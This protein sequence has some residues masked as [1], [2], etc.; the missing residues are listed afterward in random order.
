[1]NLLTEQ[2]NQSVSNKSMLT[3]LSAIK[4]HVP[5][6]ILAAYASPKTN[7]AAYFPLLQYK[8]RVDEHLENI[9]QVNQELSVRLKKAV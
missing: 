9:F 3:D 4:N 8:I 1:Q 2:T 5:S 6:A 7:W